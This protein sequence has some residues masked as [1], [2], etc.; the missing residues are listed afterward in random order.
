MRGFVL[1]ALLA[2]VFPVQSMPLAIAAV[3]DNHEFAQM[4]SGISLTIRFG[5]GTDLAYLG[6][7]A[8]DVLTATEK[9]APVKSDWYGDSVYVVAIAGIPN[10]AAAGLWWQ[11]WV[12]GELGP[13]AA[14]RFNLND[15]DSVQWRREPAHMHA[16]LT[17]PADLSVAFGAVVVGAFGLAFLGILRR[18][19]PEGH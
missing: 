14:N 10:D 12:N 2:L 1:V 5:N 11:Y 13:V 3:D 9:V 8:S 16:N 15:N 4:A 19:K 6:I 17:G 7:Q 18:K